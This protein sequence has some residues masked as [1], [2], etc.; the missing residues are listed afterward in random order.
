MKNMTV[1]AGLM[2]TTLLIGFGGQALAQDTAGG[3][4][5][6]ATAQVPEAGDIVVTGIRASIDDAIRVKRSASVILDSISAQDIGKLPD[7]NVSETLS[8]IPGVQITRVE[9]EGSKINVR[10]I[11]LNRTQYNGNNFV[12]ASNNGDPNLSDFPSEILSSVDIIKSPSADLVEGWLGAIINLKTKRPLDLRKTLLAGRIQGSYADKADKLGAKGSAAFGDTFFNDRVGILISGTASRFSGRADGYSNRGF[13]R[14]TGVPLS[15]PG[16]GNTFVFRPNRFEEYVN[17]IDTD[18]YSLNGTLQWRPVDELTFTLDGL[19]SHSKTARR[20]FVNQ[21]IFT[22]ALTRTNVLADGTIDAATVGGVTVRPIVFD[23]PSVND[24]DAI[25]FKA[26]YQKDRWTLNINASRST[27]KSDGGNDAIAQDAISYPGN[28]FVVVTRQVAG[29]TASVTY[30]NLGSPHSP[31]YTVSTN[32]DINDVSQYEGFTV[33]DQSY[34]TDN[35]SKDADFDVQYDID[36]GPLKAIK[37]GARIEEVSVFRNVNVRTYTAGQLAAGDPTPGTTLRA[38]EIAGLTYSGMITD[39]FS[40]LDGSY[41][42]SLLAGQFDVEDFRRRFGGVPSEADLVRGLASTSDVDQTTRAAF[43]RLDFGG[44]LGSMTYAGNVGVR[45]VNTKRTSSGFD[46]TGTTSVV[47]RSVDSTFNN[48]LPS[49]NLS[50]NPNDRL[51]IRLAAAKVTARP[52]LSLTGVGIT[53]QPTSGTGSAGNP[54]LAPFAATQYDISA[55]WYFAPASFISVAAFKKDV[56]AFTRTVQTIEDHPEV[57]APG[58]TNTLYTISRPVNGS[59]GR[60]TGFEVNYYHALTFL[61]SPLDGLGINASFTRSNGKTPNVD[62]LTGKTLSLP[63]LS[64]NSYN[65]VAYYEKY[66]LNLRLAY[67]YRSSYLLAQQTAALGGSLYQRGRGQL[68]A[69][70]TYKLNDTFT[71]TLDGLNLTKSVRSLYTGTTNRLTTAWQDD[72]RIYFGVSATF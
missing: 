5:A 63:N 30:D 7:Q 12:G 38:N 8:R 53:F 57:V 1:R 50:V 25:A 71:L 67:N 51:S 20:R 64:R 52:Q 72:R 28:D 18:R 4:A 23:G 70:A 60:I 11:D 43:I 46:Q 6:V 40:G 55:E 13:T 35:S 48:T 58:I 27:G 14:L 15:G 2:A 44:D 66:G 34:P 9:G 69:S 21:L 17:L 29:N 59:D 16:A 42:R 56:S 41:P 39:F 68:D 26:N 36:A 3:D 45:Q 19:K 32:Y 49:F 22:N 61:P 65:L 31:N 37:V 24:A 62:E 10:G 47:A 54:R 33:V